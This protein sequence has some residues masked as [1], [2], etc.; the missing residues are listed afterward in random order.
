MTL[1]VKDLYLNMSAAGFM[2]NVENFPVHIN[3]SP[4]LYKC[5]SQVMTNE[6]HSAV[7]VVRPPGTI[8]YHV[9]DCIGRLGCSGGR[10]FCHVGRYR[11]SLPATFLFEEEV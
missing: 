11:G 5:E 4:G 2:I 3:V 7:C 9:L 6:V 10:R 1:T 8:F